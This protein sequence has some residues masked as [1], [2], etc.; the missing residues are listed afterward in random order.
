MAQR[1]RDDPLLN[2]RRELV[3]HLRAP[4]LTGAQHLQPR[5]LD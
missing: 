2:D 1:E 5:T 4:A 3:G